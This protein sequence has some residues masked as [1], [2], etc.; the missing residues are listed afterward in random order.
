MC[1]CMYARILY[2]L[3][4][5]LLNYKENYCILPSTILLQEEDSHELYHRTAQ[6]EYNVNNIFKC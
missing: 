3:I 6:E 1:V 4:K 2:K 5:D